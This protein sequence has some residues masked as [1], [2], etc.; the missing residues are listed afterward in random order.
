MEIECSHYSSLSW[1]PNHN[2]KSKWQE[3]GGLIIKLAEDDYFI[4][5][6]GIV[7]KFKSKKNNTGI[8]SVDEV[9]VSSDGSLNF[10]RRLNG[11]E[12]HQG[13]QA[14]IPCGKVRL[15]HVKLYHY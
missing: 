12:D 6:E 9:T 1:G 10:V 3:T 15:L 8:L 11:D 14:M 4:A 5:G 7:A 13:R 2:D